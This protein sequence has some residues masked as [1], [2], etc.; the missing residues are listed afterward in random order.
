MPIKLKNPDFHR[1]LSRLIGSEPPYAWASRVG[2]SKGAFTRI[3]KEGT[4]PGAELLQRIAAA[5]EVSI[6]WLLSGR[7]RAFAA[8]PFDAPG[9]SPPADAP[10]DFIT[11]P[12]YGPHAG[13][14]HAAALGH[15]S[16]GEIIAFKRAWVGSELHCQAEDLCLLYVEGE[17]MKPVLRTRDLVL[18]DRRHAG[19]VPQDGIYVVRIDGTLLVKR[20]Q[21]LPAGQIRVTSENPAYEPFIISPADPS[22]NLTIIGRV[23]WMGR[24]L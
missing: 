23:V 20:V 15:E 10:D 7:G 1:R 14:G 4:M 17:S 18:V 5:T 6:D 16:F 2:I 24:R 3:W 13:A 19:S 12:L 21:R 22:E 8:E 9:H 11:V